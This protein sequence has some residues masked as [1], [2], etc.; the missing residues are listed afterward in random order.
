[1]G[2]DLEVGERGD[3][4]SGGEKQAI[5]L[6]RA[7]VQDPNILILDEPTSQMDNMTEQAIVQK[8]KQFCQYKTL[9]LV[10]HKTS[11]L[12]LVDRVIIVD[13]GKVIEDGAKNIILKKLQSGN[14]RVK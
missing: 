3:G 1:M 14:V 12:S 9:I 2:F 7:V 11:L 4:L 10:T 13:N 5:S 8:L 6:A